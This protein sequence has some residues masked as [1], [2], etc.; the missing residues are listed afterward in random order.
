M[1]GEEEE[2]VKPGKGREPVLILR[3]QVA[4]AGPVLCC[5]DWPWASGLKKSSCNSLGDRRD[6]G[7]MALCIAGTPVFRPMQRSGVVDFRAEEEDDWG[8]EGK[9][10]RLRSR[11]STEAG[12]TG[13]GGEQWL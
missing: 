1:I 8:E 6:I 13:R 10:G 7:H 3:T 5:S 4:L 2:R 9:Q 11:D 12:A